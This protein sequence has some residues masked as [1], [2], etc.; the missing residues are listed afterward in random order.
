MVNQKRLATLALFA[1]LFAL[2][3][4]ALGAF[5]RLIDAGLGCPDWPGC[6][7]QAIPNAAHAWGQF[8]SY[9]AWAEM[10]HRYAVGILSLLIL[11]IV[12]TI[13]F[14]KELRT[15]TN[16]TFSVFLLALLA[17][18]IML[19]QWT[20][21]LKLLP[22]IVSQHLLGGFFIL[23]TLWMIYLNNT[24]LFSRKQGS[25]SPVLLPL[26]ILGLLLVLLQ[27][28]LGAWTSTNYASLSCPDFPF[29]VNDH[30]LMPYY[31]KAA[32]NLFSPVGVNYQGGVLSDAIRQTIQMTHRFGALVVT[33]YLFVFMMFAQ[34]KLRGHSDLIRTLYVMIGLLVIQLS[35]GMMNVL[36]KL[37][38]HSAISH[39]LCAALLL[40]TMLTFIFKLL[41]VK[42]V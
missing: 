14:K 33:T 25:I 24:L 15:R 34:K 26:A 30:P 7:G 28:S 39:T 29:C 12:L 10:V 16:I 38:L 35:L 17:Y 5:T 9:K 4:I 11:S 19:G 32:F 8:V 40:I 31:F 42:S 27:I 6:Y 41:K 37:P 21:T 23:S 1:C 22:I 20:V 18:Q 2:G 13:F 36:F 3:V